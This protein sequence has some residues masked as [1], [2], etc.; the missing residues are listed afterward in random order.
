MSI[1]EL[2]QL[3]ISENSEEQMSL[4]LAIH[5]AP[6][7]SGSKAANILTVSSKK[8]AGIEKVLADTNISY[9]L[10]KTRA[11]QVILYLYREKELMQY[12]SDA[13][14]QEFLRGYGYTSFELEALLTHLSERV[15]LFSNGQAAFPHEIGSF[16]EYPLMDVKG[17]LENEGRNFKF[18]GYWKVY[19]DVQGAIRK[20]R[21]YDLERDRAVNAVMSGKQIWEIAV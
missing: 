16:L 14:V 3:R 12:L 21:Q 20:F 17:F 6:I 19:H 8:L 11:D 18:S 9:R 4:M 13:A 15:A 2:M 10:L 5:C 1:T 7:L